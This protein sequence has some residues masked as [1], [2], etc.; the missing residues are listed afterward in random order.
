M[1]PGHYNPHHGLFWLYNQLP[2]VS[3]NHTCH[4]EFIYKTQDYICIFYHFVIRWHG[5][6]KPFH[7]LCKRFDNM[8]K[9]V[10]FFW[11]IISQE[12]LKIYRW[13]M[14]DCSNSIANTLEILQSCTKPLIYPWYEFEKSKSKITAASSQEH[15]V[16][17]FRKEQSSFHLSCHQQLMTVPDCNCQLSVSL[18]EPRQSIPQ[19]TLI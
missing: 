11:P 18:S 7:Y 9:A 12:I 16:T 2:E 6:L 15:W 13:L 17:I 4:A 10:M 1:P 3:W 14:Q 5:Q 19:E 8:Y